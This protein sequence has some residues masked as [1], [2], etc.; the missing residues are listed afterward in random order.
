MLIHRIRVSRILPNMETEQ[1]FAFRMAGTQDQAEA[2][3]HQMQTIWMKRNP[4]HA[5]TMT[6]DWPRP[7]ELGDKYSLPS[8]PDVVRW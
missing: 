5:T 2:F 8:R 7:E 6:T 1:V 3:G 4:G